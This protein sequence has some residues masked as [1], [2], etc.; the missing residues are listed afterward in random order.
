M[1]NDLINGISIKL[2]QVFGDEYRIYTNSVTQGLIEPCFFIAV[3]N[4]SQAQ[5]IGNR[6][7]R[8][9]LFDIHYFPES[10]GDNEEIQNVASQLF[11]TLEYINLPN[12]TPASNKY[13][14]AKFPDVRGNDLKIVI[15]VNA[16]DEESYDVITMYNDNI[17]DS[18]IVSSAVELVD[19]DYLT[20][21]TTAELVETIGLPL[22]G[23]TNG[24]LIRG[25]EMRYEK[26]D[27]VL[28]FFVNYNMFLRK[29][30]TLEDDME[31]IIYSGGVKLNE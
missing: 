9:H 19:N 28:H 26:I 4:S 25:T 27:G 5:L 14:K 24:D 8:Q 29:D 21:I 22:T 1:V 17:V 18:Q 11:N 12:G 6:Y 3:V 16:E 30:I 13:A 23:G 31:E 2:N 15:T 10:E 20:F 7:F